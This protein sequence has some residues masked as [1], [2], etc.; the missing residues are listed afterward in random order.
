MTF[1]LIDNVKIDWNTPWGKLTQSFVKHEK[2][3]QKKKK[4]KKKKK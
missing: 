4:K 1:V 3:K 2:Q